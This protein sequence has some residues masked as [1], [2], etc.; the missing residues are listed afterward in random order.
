MPAVFDCG[1]KSSDCLRRS[2]RA[3]EQELPQ[4]IE[5]CVQK[6]ADGKPDTSMFCDLIK[7][8]LRK[9]VKCSPL[10]EKPAE[11]SSDIRRLPYQSVTR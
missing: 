5:A 1:K 9:K 11:W 10:F 4:R 3:A 7:G 2:P 8:H 6:M